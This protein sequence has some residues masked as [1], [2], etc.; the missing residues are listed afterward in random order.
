MDTLEA[1]PE[2]YEQAARLLAT[3]HAE[4]QDAPVEFYLFP[5]PEK[6]VVRLLEV[7]E[8]FPAAQAVWP[9]TFGQSEDFPFDTAVAMITPDEWR[10]VQAGQRS[11]PEGWDISKRVQVQA[12][13]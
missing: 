10:Q 6:R 3:W 7:S 1:I 8:V 12:N 13:E 2:T 11:L 5:D 9:I 4:A